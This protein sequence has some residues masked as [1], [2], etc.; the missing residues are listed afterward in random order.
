MPVGIITLVRVC[1]PHHDHAGQQ[2]CCRQYC[3][4]HTVLVARLNKR[5]GQNLFLLASSG[6]LSGS[7]HPHIARLFKRPTHR[8]VGVIVKIGNTLTNT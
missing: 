7:R 6:G 8:M 4:Y 1:L 2:G 3:S 5:L